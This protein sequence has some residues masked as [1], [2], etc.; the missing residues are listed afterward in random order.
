[1]SGIVGIINLDGKP[2]SQELLRRMT[3]SL[4]FR[5][6]DA[7]EIWSD[8]EVG[9]GHAMLRTTRESLGEGQPFS[10]DGEIWITADARIDGRSDLLAGLECEGLASL[11]RATGAE[12]ILHAYNTWGE[13]CL[14]HLIGDFVF[15]IWDAQKRCLFCARDHFGVKPFYYA[16]VADCLVFSNTLNCVRIHPAVSDELNDLAIGDFLLFGYNQEVD[17]TTFADIQRLPPAHYLSWSDRGLQIKRYWTLP[18]CGRIRYKR[19]HEY[20]DHFQELLHEAVYDR[21]RTDHAAV[22]MSGGLDST[23]IAATAGELLSRESKP[24]DL[25]AFTIVYDRLIPDQE[26]HYS[27]L[28]AKAL[29][30]PIHYLVADDYKLFERWDR[31]ELHYPEPNEFPF[32]ALIFDYLSQA[33]SSNRVILSGEGG[34]PVMFYSWA[35]LNNLVKEFQWGSL[36]KYIARHIRLYKQFP[37]MGFR[38]TLRNWMGKNYRWQ[39]QYPAWLNESFARRSDLPRRLEQTNKVPAPVH[40]TRP[41]AYNNF[42]QS[43]WLDCFERGDPGVTTVPIEVRYPFFDIRVVNYFLSIPPIPWCVNKELLREAMRDI[44]PDTVRLRPKAS[45]A[46]DPLREVLRLGDAKWVDR[47]DATPRLANYVNTGEIP[48]IAGE[49]DSDQIRLNIRPLCLNYWLQTLKTVNI[50]A[51]QEAHYEITS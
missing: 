37:R 50:P 32:T 9:F 47:F 46:G 41:E 5:G 1:M 26:R 13:E 24:F 6:P 8:G 10:L 44:L 30:I 31:S 51:Y 23:A 19:A 34:D 40:P 16:R 39:Y 7:Q 4:T 29:H 15:S 36:L 18:S 38:S 43:A 22:S 49:G 20:V 17:T 2:V 28:A 48:R 27:G 14:D 25:Q 11:D 12:L 42:L 3:A 35:D 33:A 21:L 45:L